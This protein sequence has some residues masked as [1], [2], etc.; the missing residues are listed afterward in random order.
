MTYSA[1]HC[2]DLVVLLQ[3]AAFVGSVGNWSITS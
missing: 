2:R 3:E 1:H